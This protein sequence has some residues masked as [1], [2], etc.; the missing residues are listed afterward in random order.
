MRFWK[1]EEEES[2]IDFLGMCSDGLGKGTCG[3]KKARG[4]C[5]DV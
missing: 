3:Y 1:G 5:E 2:Q 4:D